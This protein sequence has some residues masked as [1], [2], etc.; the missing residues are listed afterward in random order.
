MNWEAIGAIGEMLG[1]LGVVGSLLFVGVQLLHNTKALRL[2]GTSYLLEQLANK[3]DAQASNE[4]VSTLMFKGMPN[5]ESLEGLDYHRF[6]LMANSL[7]LY[8]ANAHYQFRA[9]A[10]DEE[11]WESICSQLT[12]VMNAPG[13]L[14]YWVK[15]GGNFPLAFRTFMNG[16]VIGAAGEQWQMAGTEQVQNSIANGAVD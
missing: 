9:S 16:E 8:F 7:V 13:M 1:A 14:D 4:N 15:R 5:P 2:N 11:T 3:L 10:L 6:T 12:N